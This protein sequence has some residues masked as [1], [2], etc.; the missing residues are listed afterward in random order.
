M[1]NPYQPPQAAVAD[2]QAPAGN[3][4]ERSELAPKPKSVLLFQVLGCVMVVLLLLGIA[5]TAFALLQ[6]A[7]PFG[8]P[9]LFLAGYGA[10]ILI[11]ALVVSALVATFRR[12]PIGRTLGL[13]CIAGFFALM[14]YA[15]FFNTAPRTLPRFEYEN[16]QFGETAEKAFGLFLLLGIAYWFY[17]FGFSTKSRLFFGVP[18][19]PSIEQV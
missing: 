9:V 1:S 19:S 6:G 8:S 11:A 5:R 3:K 15:Q 14:V 7:R 17:V 16:P 13:L 18:G 12:R 4:S 10:Q 2:I